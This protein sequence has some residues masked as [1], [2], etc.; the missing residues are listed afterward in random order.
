MMRTL[1]AMISTSMPV[2]TC[3]MMTSKTRTSRIL[4]KPKVIM[5]EKMI[6]VATV[7]GHLKGWYYDLNTI[8]KNK[9]DLED[10]LHVEEISKI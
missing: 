7:N 1:K 4:R 6:K 8:D 9:I 3:S 10:S 2:G 5:D